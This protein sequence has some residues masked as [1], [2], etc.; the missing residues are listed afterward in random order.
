MTYNLIKDMPGR[1]GAALSNRYQVKAFKTSDD[2]HKFL[3]KQYD[4]SWRILTGHNLKSGIYFSQFDKNGAR[5]INV[6]E[7]SI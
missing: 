6:K 4:N 2:M 7:L 5:Y 1:E 3:N